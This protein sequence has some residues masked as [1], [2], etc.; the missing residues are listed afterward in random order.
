MNLPE[1]YER[2]VFQINIKNAK[3]LF[4]AI[5]N[6]Q[7]DNFQVDMNEIKKIHQAKTKLGSYNQDSKKI[8]SNGS[9]DSLNLYNFK[10]NFNF[11][12]NHLNEL[13]RNPYG[14]PNLQNIQ[15]TH[16][17]YGRE[18]L[19]IMHKKEI[20][21]LFLIYNF[22]SYEVYEKLIHFFK[23]YDKQNNKIISKPNELIPILTNK[24]L[25]LEL[26]KKCKLLLSSC[27]L[28]VFP[29]TYKSYLNNNMLSWKSGIYFYTCSKKFKHF[30]PLHYNIDGKNFNI[31]NL[32]SPLISENSDFIEYGEKINCDCGKARIDAKFVGHNKNMIQKNYNFILE[33]FGENISGHY[34][35]LQLFL[36]VN[37][38]LYIAY[39]SNDLKKDIDK[40]LD[41]LKP[42]K[43]HLLKNKKI[44][45]GKDKFPIIWKQDDINQIENLDATIS[46]AG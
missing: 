20:N 16:M 9:S 4:D 19:K 26:S 5:K 28:A 29:N 7:F 32:N 37:N 24:E 41:V 39:K 2:Y 25:S 6:Y 23:T 46:C 42:N 30:L 22:F 44:R 36:D 34:L 8:K 18:D 38:E 1:I 11:W 35:W 17:N 15:L 14:F 3:Q 43:C 45:V 13:I 12:H 40:F 27:D 31:L 10:P 21:T 33:D